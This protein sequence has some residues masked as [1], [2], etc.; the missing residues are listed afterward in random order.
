MK[1]KF[2][3]VSAGALAITAVV[4]P[5]LASAYRGDPNAQGP[6][7]SEEQHAAVTTA[8]E[9]GD[10]SAWSEEMEG[11]GV[12]RRINENNFSQFQEMHRLNLAGD[13]EGAARIRA[14]LG[15]GLQDGSGSGQG[16]GA[17]NGQGY[18]RNR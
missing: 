11:R 12:S 15:L 4:A 10:Y 6:N 7:Y 18:G 17:G 16:Q 3:L 8:L 9:S 14:E 2:I 1:N 5:Q 13:S